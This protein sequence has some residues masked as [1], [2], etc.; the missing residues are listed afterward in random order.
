MNACHK[1]GHTQGHANR[2]CFPAVKG[3]PGAEAHIGLQRPT[4]WLKEHESRQLPPRWAAGHSLRETLSPESTPHELHTS[5]LRM[6]ANDRCHEEL[7]I[8]WL[9]LWLP[10]GGITQL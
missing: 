2:M 9:L 10:G 1:Q 8:A 5:Q 7:Q 6:Q 3:H 4:L